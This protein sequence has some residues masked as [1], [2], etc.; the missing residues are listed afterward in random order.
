MKAT[1]AISGPAFR[2]LPLRPIASRRPGRGAR[3][4][5]ASLLASLCACTGQI[6]GPP[7]DPA[8][9]GS[10][11]QP[12]EP[13]S[14]AGPAGG[15]PGAAACNPASKSFAPARVWQLSD[16]QY[17]NVVRDVFGITL[18]EEDGRIVSAGAADRYT[19]Y[20]EELAIDT[21]VAPN[22]QTAAV[23]VADLAEAR[24]V[25]LVGAA[26]PTPAQ[27]RSFIAT[28]VARA[29]RRPV[30]LSEATALTRIYTDAQADGAGRGFHLVIEAALQSPSFL[31]RTELGDDAA[32]AA[33]PVQL[34]PFELASALSFL[35]LETSPDD[36]LWSRAQSGAI[37]D[38]AVLAAEVDRLMKLPAA[39]AN[40]ALKASYWLGLAGVTNRSRSN[41]LYPEWNE[42]F[43][44]ALAQ[45]VQ[46][47]VADVVNNGQLSDL[48]SSNRVYLNQQLAQ[49]YGVAGVTGTRL[50]PVAVPGTVRSA[51]ILSQP[52][53]IVAAN[54]L[55]D[56]ADV[57]HRGLLINDAFVCGGNV[58]P[59]PPEAG[60]EAKKMDGTERERAASRAASSNCR[61]CH[62]KFDPFGL[63][64]ERYDA[65]GRYHETRQAVLDS[66]TGTT[67]FQTS[68]SPIDAS[69]VLPD[70]G[71][72]D[73]LAGP[74]DGL[75]ELAARLAGAGARVGLCASRRLAEYSLGVDPDAE[76]SCELEAVKQVLVKTGSF[77]EF[78]RALVLSPGF[79][80]R[81]PRAAGP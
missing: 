8:G 33:G 21:Q 68:A 26:D 65:L 4:A 75:N 51:G 77:S 74:V 64:F 58:P 79:R 44:A 70:D 41:Q 14:G 55:I 56:R 40:M 76:S 13:P 9:G 72:G 59:A 11:G 81:N 32:R 62:A 28:K 53:L 6:A 23:R 15:S 17:V 3:P 49:V 46:L 78:F 31:Y 63:A 1:G 34:G 20:S 37:L 25:S 38:P 69:A 45:S 24:M 80:T 54:R 71:Q 50:L 61:P 22:Y 10:S 18:S 48:F 67:T 47:F 36:G 39:R 52:G 16:R 30:S 66:A 5:L 35:F 7:G 29:W 42:P 2:L 43:K 60:D 19:N 27:V 12:G 57:V 73:M